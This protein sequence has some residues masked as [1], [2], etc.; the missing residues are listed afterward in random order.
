MTRRLLP[1]RVTAWMKI[2]LLIAIRKTTDRRRRKGVAMQPFCNAGGLQCKS[3]ASLTRNLLQVTC[4]C[5]P[6]A[7]ILFMYLTFAFR[8][9]L[10]MI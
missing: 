5:K 4:T 9:S 6:L 10:F 7:F 2:I 1:L 8:I 3:F